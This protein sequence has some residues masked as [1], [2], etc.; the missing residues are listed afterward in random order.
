MMQG[1]IS[2]NFIYF[3]FI[4]STYFDLAGFL[5]PLAPEAGRVD[6]N[7]SRG[8]N[9]C[10]AGFDCKTDVG[11]DGGKSAGCNADSNLDEGVVGIGA[12]V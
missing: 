2:M 12:G 7:A 1:P 5:A 10:A 4:T 9:F 8:S 3:L 6:N 11:L